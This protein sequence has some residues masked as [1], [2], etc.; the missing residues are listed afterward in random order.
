VKIDYSLYLVTDR[1]LSL[2]RDIVEVVG[3]AA[4]GGVTVVQL[5]EKEATTREFLTIG[6]KIIELLKEKK[7]PLI[8]ND[9]IDI[10]LALDAEG[11]HLGNNDMPIEIARKILG[12]KKIIGL[13]AEC[14]EDAIEADKKGADY[15]GVSPVYTTPT[16][17][18]LETGL[19]IKGLREIRKVTKVPL[20]AIGGMKAANCREIIENGA[21]GIAVVS[22][23]CSAPDPG[24]ASKEIMSEILKG[25]KTSH[26]LKRNR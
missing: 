9:R 6:E 11:V 26:E 12:D 24:E 15:I 18:E 5:R 8:I 1:D 4:A 16:K 17:P 21:D 22:G 14:V 25:R 23:I 19:G 10:A 13:S 7:I 3:R 2:G 20:V